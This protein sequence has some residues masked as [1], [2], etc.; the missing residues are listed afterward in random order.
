M[1]SLSIG[2]RVN[3]KE[4]PGTIRFF[5][6]TSFAPG[7]WV[8]VELDNPHGKN[9]G[10]VQGTRYFDC[11]K[12]GNYGVFVR[13]NLLLSTTSKSLLQTRELLDA[14]K[15]VIRLQDKL[16]VARQEIADNKQQIE[17]LRTALN[18]KSSLFD[19]LEIK[20]EGLVV[21]QNYLKDRN[22]SLSKQLELLQE[23]YNEVSADY[24]ILQEESELNKELELAVQ[25]QVSDGGDVTHDDLELLVLRNKK[26]EITLQS[27]Q[28][29]SS[30]REAQ[31]KSEIFTLRKNNT[32]ISELRK[33]YAIIS[34][35]LEEA[36][37]TVE[38]LQEQ[39][40][41]VSAL[42]LVI[43]NLTQKNEVLQAKVTELT[44]SVTELMELNELNTSLEE[45]QLK[46]EL[47]LKTQIE[48]LVNDVQSWKDK[49]SE[50]SLRNE[51]L[52]RTI[53]NIKSAPEFVNQDNS[54]VEEL[55]LDVKKLTAL[56]KQ[57][58]LE[59]KATSEDLRLKNNLISKVIPASI[60]E[61][62]R[63]LTALQKSASECDIVREHFLEDLPN[64]RLEDQ[65]L[66][67]HFRHY[68]LILSALVEFGVDKNTPS[69]ESLQLAASDAIHEMH[70]IFNKVKNDDTE[71][72]NLTFVEK[73]ALDHP[74]ILERMNLDL[75]R[76]FELLDLAII[77]EIS[78]TIIS[79]II[80]DFFVNQQESGNIIQNLKDHHIVASRVSSRA[81]ALYD[82]LM[83]S[84]CK[85]DWNFSTPSL[86]QL[87][88]LL[89]QL[90]LKLRQE[91]S[92][93][94]SDD[95]GPDKLISIIGNAISLGL[96]LVE[97]TRDF[98]RILDSL[99]TDPTN[100]SLG[101]QSFYSE[102]FEPSS[103]ND[104]EV[105]TNIHSSNDQVIEELKHNIDL[106]EKNMESLIKS[107]RIESDELQKQLSDAKREVADL[108][109]LYD[110]LKKEN[111][112]IEAEL[113]LILRS[114]SI[115]SHHQV[116]FF[117]DLKARM[118][119]TNELALVE[120]VS[121]LK[122]MVL[123]GI[124]YVVDT[125]DD[126]RW[127]EAP[128]FEDTSSLKR[129][130]AESFAQEARIRREQAVWLLKSLGERK[131]HA[132]GRVRYRMLY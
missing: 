68:A 67:L 45:Y 64:Q 58:K 19:D 113:E 10:V 8:G 32:D 91:A 38:Q 21:D 130:N 79:R 5:G 24:A 86:T 110:A 90:Y 55:V 31:F 14:E 116:P 121:L 73:I 89:L 70:Q 62:F 82:T 65:L 9:N 28:K 30:E 1:A 124:G 69:W 108:Q 66:L 100:Q 101:I 4:E 39:L 114:N 75:H 107:Q 120:E 105:V 102:L 44:K 63:I 103:F 47:E 34:A 112:A 127:L 18:A 7:K 46:M 11:R 131:P 78:S 16:K 109:S 12:E 41:S 51:D 13:P 72:L 104:K 50:L 77:A 118:K 122:D 95:H 61:R 42:D 20:L 117:E 6:T 26:L 96:L 33:S 59:L 2:D 3:V 15:I 115:V 111:K 52:Q 132:T 22:N 74:F 83:Q 128:L 35:K 85:S 92:Y 76:L 40:E 56:I 71:C 93:Y 23:K 126:I 94:S 57:D 43:E 84:K 99:S 125:L 37:T 106:L 97:G 27:L 48:T 29:L 98:E 80:A 60:A 119:F 87:N 25:L 49:F 53:G 36:E 129:F 54:R 123:C 81:H 88:S 17:T